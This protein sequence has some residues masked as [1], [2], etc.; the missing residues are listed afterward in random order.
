MCSVETRE[1]QGLCGG[2]CHAVNYCGK[3]CK[4][5]DWPW[6]KLICEK[7]EVNYIGRSCKI[8][9]RTLDKER[10]EEVRREV[11]KFYDSNI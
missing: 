10:E 2:E 11:E 6:H 3:K 9:L 4:D 8:R 5:R 7:M 1:E